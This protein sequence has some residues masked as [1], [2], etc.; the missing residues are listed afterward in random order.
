MVVCAED[1][2]L[3][4]SKDDVSIE[5]LIVHGQ[6]HRAAGCAE[7]HTPNAARRHQGGALF[8]GEILEHGLFLWAFYFR[9]VASRFLR[10]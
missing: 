2:T 1:R 9:A 5:H 8:F 10:R 7:H 6:G 3:A 4:C